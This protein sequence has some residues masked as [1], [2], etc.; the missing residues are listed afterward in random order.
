MKHLFRL[1]VVPP[2]LGVFVSYRT[3]IAALAAG[4]LIAGCSQNAVLSQSNASASLVQA[5]NSLSV[6]KPSAGFK[7]PRS[8]SSKSDQYLFVANKTNYGTGYVTVYD[9]TQNNL[10]TTLT[11][12]VGEPSALGVSPQGYLYVANQDNRGTVTVY[13]SKWNVTHTMNSSILPHS[14]LFDSANNLYVGGQKYASVFPDARTPKYKIRGTG[15]LAVDAAGNVYISSKHEIDIYQPGKKKNYKS[16]PLS[17]TFS[18]GYLAIDSS[19]NLYVGS[20]P[21]GQCG[22]VAVYNTSTDSLEY[23]ITDGICEPKQIAESP[24]GNIY[25]LNANNGSPSVT[26]YSPGTTTLL[27]TVTAGLN[28]SNAVTFDANGDLY[29]SNV[30]N[31][32]VYAPG[33]DS[34]L[35]T[36]TDAINGSDGVAFGVLK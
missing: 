2:L 26:V 33:S 23:T 17:G 11:K 6:A 22:S 15:G 31:V 32:T 10:V 34:V 35:R 27:R 19:G 20:T 4:A 18:F 24:D 29:V 36:I 21:Y 14:I 7:A 13:G 1:V 3:I 12:D 30:A 8:A 28:D 9:T 16:I 5:T 25:V